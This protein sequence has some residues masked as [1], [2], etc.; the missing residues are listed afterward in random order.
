MGKRGSSHVQEKGDQRR[1]GA[2]A[3][4][5][6]STHVGVSN[7]PPSRRIGKTPEGRCKRF[8]PRAALS[9]TGEKETDEQKTHSPA[10]TT[11][12]TRTAVSL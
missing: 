7:Q 6:Q 9:E 5:H 3:K 4:Q 10:L 11:R 1:G 2:A 12:M 8:I